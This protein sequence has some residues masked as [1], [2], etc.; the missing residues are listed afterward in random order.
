MKANTFLFLLLVS[1]S[2]TGAVVNAGGHAAGAATFIPKTK[3]QLPHQ[4]EC[5]KDT[6]PH[7]Q[8]SVSPSSTT[9]QF[10]R[11]GAGP[12]KSETVAKFATIITILNSAMISLAPAKTLEMY[13][14][15]KT[16]LTEYMTEWI[17]QISTS[18]AITQWSLY[19]NGNTVNTAMGAG[20]LY[21]VV[22]SI[23]S[24]LNDM[25]AQF[26]FSA[27]GQCIFLLIN[28]FCGYSLLYNKSHADDV[29][30]YYPIWGLLN[31]L[32]FVVAPERMGQKWG[33]EGAEPDALVTYEMKQTGFVLASKAV[34]LLSLG[35]GVDTTKALGYG[36]VPALLGMV[37]TNFISKEIELFGMDANQQ[38]FWL[39]L[40]AFVIG[41]LAF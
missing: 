40:K 9:V 13:G 28:I 24:L 39:L 16:P 10:V 6:P 22:F 36:N 37:I 15:D 17:G 34:Y 32:A 5:L 19:F 8:K 27:I 41:S 25:P 38:W 4:N 1:L 30:K 35:L 29:A 2:L 14:L 3:L 11:G 18:Q 33:V 31:A 23:K 21:L 20:T 26:G 7:H 12:F